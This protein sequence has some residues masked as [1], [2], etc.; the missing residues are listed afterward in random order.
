MIESG[1]QDAETLK[2]RIDAG[3]AWLAKPGLLERDRDAEYAAVL[4]ID[5]AE[6]T[7]PIVCCP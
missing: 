6:I 7:E 4:E 2:R 5:L 1:Y 3:E